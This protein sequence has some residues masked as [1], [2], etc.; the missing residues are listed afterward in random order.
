M[1]RRGFTFVEL[2]IALSLFSVG[3]LSILQIFPINRR[4]LNQSSYQT[5][6]AFLAEEQMET[7]RS[8]A[9]SALTAGTYEAKATVP[10]STG[11]V[12]SLFQRS[13]TIDY[14]NSSYAVSGTDTGLKRL[15][16]T[17]YW[18]EGSVN[19]SYVLSTYDYNK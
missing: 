4:L 17:V 3:M 13:T 8:L 16:V 1:R 18:S 15:T 9:Y 19:R 7:L 12:Y 11:T 6:A 14:I 2:L 10:N 5:D